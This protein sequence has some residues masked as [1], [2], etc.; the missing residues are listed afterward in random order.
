MKAIKIKNTIIPVAMLQEW[1]VTHIEGAQLIDYD[2]ETPTHQ[3]QVKPVTKRIH[4][5]EPAD[6]EF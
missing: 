6:D 1:I 4:K 5:T 2:P 3:E